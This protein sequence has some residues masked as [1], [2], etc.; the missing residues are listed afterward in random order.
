MPRFIRVL[1]PFWQLET[2]MES[3]IC[4]AIKFGY[5]RTALIG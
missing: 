4:S 2:K 3:K 5:N 1:Q